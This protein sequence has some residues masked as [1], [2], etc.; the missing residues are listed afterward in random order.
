MIKQVSA[1]A[2]FSIF[3]CTAN[4]QQ[5]SIPYSEQM[6]KT[7]QAIW[8]DSFLIDGDKTPKWRYDQGVVLKGVEDVWY[9]SGNGDYFKYIQKSMDYYVQEDGSIKGYKPQEYNI[10]HVNNGRMLLLLYQI[11][12]KEKYK[13]AADLLRG[14]LYTHPRTKE[15]GFWHKEIYPYQMWLDGLYMGE[16]FYAFYAQLFGQDTCFNDITNQFVWM[17]KHARDPKTGL[18]YHGW[19]ESKAQQWANKTTGTSPHFWGRALGWYGMAMVDVLDYFPENHPGRKSIIQILNRMVAA[20]VKVQ[21][22]ASGV[23]YDIVDMPTAKGNY[24]E[25]SAS[26][27]LVYTIA[28]AVRKNYIPASYLTNAKKG[29]NG[30]I[31]EFIKVENGQTNLYGTVAV[32]GLG[33]KPYRN[34][35]FEYYM[36]EPVRVNDPKGMG[37]FIQC[38]VEMEMVSTQAVG[39]GQKVVLDQ[40]FN[41]ELRN[42]AAGK[43]DFWHYVWQEKSH[44]GFYALGKIFN[45]YGASLSSLSAAPTAANLKGASVYII[46]DPDHEKD[47]PHAN[48]M[49][50]E[51][52]KAIANWVKQGGVLLIMA[53]DSSNCDLQHFNLLAGAFGMSFTNDSRN[54][55][56]NDQFETGVVMS[57]NNAVFKGDYKMYLKEISTITVKAPATPLISKNNEVVIATAKYGK[58][59]VFAVGDPW[60]YNEYVDGRKL[61]AQYENWRAAN[62]LVQWLLKN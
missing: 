18:L 60:L 58:G 15:G 37:A 33:G 26:S 19:D 59:A 46:V 13:K 51:Q 40:Y 6:V 34:G 43:P 4:A 14:Q 35:S 24:K 54:M 62:D 42:N 36:S 30:I 8:P 55:V 3:C 12:G 49:Q 21:D 32:S 23:W 5:K 25:A 53:N 28:K 52:V 50:P 45:Q 9:A 11:T 22:P 10:D 2:L 61:P 16:P 20:V 44:P 41:S 7:A 31:K 48:Y 29:W 1:I 57:G 27:M 39:K 47:K 38:A 17:E 56:K